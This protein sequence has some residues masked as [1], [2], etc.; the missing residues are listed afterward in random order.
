MTKTG[1]SRWLSYLL[2]LNASKCPCTRWEVV[3]NTNKT[4]ATSVRKAGRIQKNMGRLQ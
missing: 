1:K 2:S 4:N 3:V